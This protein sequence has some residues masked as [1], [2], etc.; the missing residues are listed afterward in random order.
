MVVTASACVLHF[1]SVWTSATRCTGGGGDPS[2]SPR[3]KPLFPPIRKESLRFSRR[4]A[5]EAVRRG[6]TRSAS[7]PCPLRSPA[8]IVAAISG[9]GIKPTQGGR[10]FAV[11]LTT[12]RA[13]GART[14]PHDSLQLV[15]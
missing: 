9:S 12:S 14:L 10:A 15:L 5:R 1:R 11:T 7:R 13:A 3:G 4:R 2:D 8:D 6:R